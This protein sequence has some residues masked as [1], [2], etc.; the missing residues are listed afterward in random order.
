MGRFHIRGWDL[1]EGSLPHSGDIIGMMFSKGNHPQMTDLFR[2]V[3]S[4]YVK[5][6]I[7]M[8]ID[9]GFTH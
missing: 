8:A 9:S 1:L 4:G 3:P 5:I 6:A 7:K 2:L